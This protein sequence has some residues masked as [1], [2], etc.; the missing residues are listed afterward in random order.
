MVWSQIRS[1]VLAYKKLVD[2]LDEKRV[3]SGRPLAIVYLK[4]NIFTI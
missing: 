2:R 3:T 1:H 4:E